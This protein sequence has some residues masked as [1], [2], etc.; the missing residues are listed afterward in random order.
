[1]MSINKRP[2]KSRPRQLSILAAEDDLDQQFVLQSYFS[3]TPHTL[4]FVRNGL[5]AVEAVRENHF[6]LVLM[7]IAMPIMDGL[8]ATSHIRAWEKRQCLPPI[9]I[10]ALTAHAMKHHKI[11]CIE[12]G[13]NAHISK[14]VYMET[15]FAAVRRWTLR[16]PIVDITHRPYPPLTL[17]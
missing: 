12:A 9:P 5:L 16:V 3:K 10:I 7:D 17:S 14:P 11:S 4:T 15:L 2:V 1:M 6:D 8:E 13:C